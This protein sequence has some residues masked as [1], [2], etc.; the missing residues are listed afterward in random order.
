MYSNSCPIIGKLVQ[1]IVRGSASI[2]SMKDK[3]PLEILVEIGI[4]K[5]RRDYVHAFVCEYCVLI[6]SPACTQCRFFSL[7][8]FVTASYV[9]GHQGGHET[10]FGN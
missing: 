7:S 4:E 5:L 9:F 3:F 8:L 1:S 2:P 10:V 6:I